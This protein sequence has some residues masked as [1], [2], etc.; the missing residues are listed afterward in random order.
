MR[1]GRSMLK[2]T[3][4]KRIAIK[5]QNALLPTQTTFFRGVHQVVPAL[6]KTHW[7]FDTE[8]FL[9]S[10]DYIHEQVVLNATNSS[11]STSFNLVGAVDGF[12]KVNNNVNVG[13]R[14]MNE[15]VVHRFRNMSTAPTEIIIWNC[16]VK[17]DIPFGDTGYLLSGGYSSLSDLWNR[18]LLMLTANNNPLH[19]TSTTV[20]SSATA[21]GWEADP[22]IQLGMSRDW[23]QYISMK[24]GKRMFI[25]AGG[26]VFKTV[27][28]TLNR[29]IT[30][31]DMI[32]FGNVTTTVLYNKGTSFL[33]W[34]VRGE[35]THD[36][37]ARIGYG[38]TKLDFIS[39]HTIKW[40]MEQ[41]MQKSIYSNAAV[42]YGDA[43]TLSGLQ[44]NP[45]FAQ[46]EI[47]AQQL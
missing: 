6:N 2:A 7:F 25:Q 23:N 46:P 47:V 22:M 5:L 28:R 37:Q 42:P 17:K 15:K 13:V 34:E 29:R 12:N 4:L 24:K 19:T 43:L 21:Q 10:D 45:G 35:I 33:L 1:K 40:K 39:E 8:S 31:E 18:G 36:D 14:I 20:M 16:Y 38:T 32:K 11:I 26:Q 3:G 27:K 44:F 9:N 30:A 41:A